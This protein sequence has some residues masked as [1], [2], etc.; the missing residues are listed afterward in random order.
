MKRQP[1]FSRNTVTL[2][3]YASL[4]CLQ[5]ICSTNK[6]AASDRIAVSDMK[7]NRVLIF[8]TP[9]A[10]NERASVVLGQADF[11]HGSPNRG[12][13]PAADTLKMPMGLTK[14]S[15]GNLYVADLGNCRVLQFRPPFTSGMNAS[16]I[17]QDPGFASASC[18]TDSLD[19]PLRVKGL[20]VPDSVAVDNGGNLFVVDTISSRVLE[21]SPPFSSAMV[22][23]LVLGQST[24]V[25]PSVFGCVN[26]L[27]DDDATARTL[28]GP[29]GIAFDSEGN[30]WVADSGDNRVLEFVPP[31]FPGMAARLEV[32]QPAE[33]AF[34]STLSHPRQCGQGSGRDDPDSPENENLCPAGRESPSGE[35]L[36]SPC[37]LAF[38][39]GGNL[40]VADGYNG[41]ILE[42]VPPFSNGMAAA[43]VVGEEDFRHRSFGGQTL[44][45]ISANTLT[46]GT[47]L[48]FDASGNLLVVDHL[49]HRVLIFNPPIRSAMPAASV[50]GS[51]DFTDTNLT[52]DGRYIP[53]RGIAANLFNQPIH[54]VV[55]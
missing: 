46:D 40:W 36:Y 26:H 30:L 11:V 29:E 15:S 48:A 47:D 55:F 27:R 17:I 9:L 39:A 19:F 42:F 52:P 53:H 37:S 50:L 54:L 10:K 18:N 14:D 21:Y 5:C 22:P 49:E 45:A 12:G 25:N 51:A 1:R 44:Q 3:L 32:G 20:V 13:D 16:L 33:T 28:C 4:G 7:N 34:T 6:L 8:D 38:D 43:T 35:S 41:R 2:V 23:K 24:A 31:F